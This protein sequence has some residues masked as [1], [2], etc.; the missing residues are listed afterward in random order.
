MPSAILVSS[1]PIKA[2]L[3]MD[4][5][6]TGDIGVSPKLWTLLGRIVLETAFPPLACRDVALAKA[7]PFSPDVI[8]VPPDVTLVTFLTSFSILPKKPPICM[9]VR[10]FHLLPISPLKA[11]ALLGRIIRYLPTKSRIIRPTSR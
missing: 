10:M 8:S 2:N 1:P 5:T 4:R 6:A 3:P 7:G 9:I 11:N